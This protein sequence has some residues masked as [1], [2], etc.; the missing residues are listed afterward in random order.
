MRNLLA[1]FAAA[2]LV[3]L[4]AG[5]HLGWYTVKGIPAPPGHRVVEID[6]DTD[7]IRDD[8]HRGKEKL[9]DALDR[10]RPDD[11]SKRAETNRLG[12]MKPAPKE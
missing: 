5:W 3:F 10:G 12:P 6:V 1:F 7:K 11:H 8:V 4:G 9:S 2:L